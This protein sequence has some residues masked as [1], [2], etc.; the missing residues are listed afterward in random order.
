[1]VHGLDI[2]PSLS[3]ESLR[4]DLIKTAKDV[5]SEVGYSEDNPETYTVLGMICE[6]G[7]AQPILLQM[8]STRDASFALKHD[9]RLRTVSGLSRVF[10]IPYLS[11]DQRVKHQGLH[12]ELKTKVEEFPNQHLVIRKGK[13]NSTGEQ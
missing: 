9:K 2:N 5:I 3:K 4:D 13:V 12:D 1:M 6:S 8:K 10:I 7:K 11:K